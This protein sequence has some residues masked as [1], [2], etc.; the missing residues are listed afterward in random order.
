MLMKQV[1]ELV[2]PTESGNG[3]ENSSGSMIRN[4]GKTALP[5]TT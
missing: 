3:K 5:L 2:L 4:S 1:L